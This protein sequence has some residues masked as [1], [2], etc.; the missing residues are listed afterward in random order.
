[1]CHSSIVDFFLK[2]IK[3]EEFENAEVLE[4]G[5]RDV[6]GTIRPIIEKFLKIKKYLGIDIAEGKFVDIVL[7][8]EKIA[9]YFGNDAFD[10][11]ISTEVL[12]HV[13]DWRLVINNIKSVLKAGGYVYLTTRSK[14]FKYH[15]YPNDFWRYEIN[16][17]K[18]IFSDFKIITLVKDPIK[19]G[20][21]FKALKPK[22]WKPKDLS[23][24]K[25]YSMILGKRTLS[26]PTIEQMPRT[27]RLKLKYSA[28]INRLYEV[29][30]YH[31]HRLILK[32]FNILAR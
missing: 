2:V 31:L 26:N 23:N 5:S 11:V 17:F 6:N 32:I 7:P 1:M 12:E 3:P 21:L 18:N 30:N 24:I 29:I 20:I 13:K 25:L 16:D 9:E 15:A 19:A 8:A 28:K 10:I 22:D 14:G 27:R 4:I